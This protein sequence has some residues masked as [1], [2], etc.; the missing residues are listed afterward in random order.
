[1][2]H[3]GISSM[4][5]T[6]SAALL[7][8]LWFP[9][10]N[11]EVVLPGQSNVPIAEHSFDFDVVEQKPRDFNFGGVFAH[12]V[13]S[14][15]SVNGFLAFETQVSIVSAPS[16]FLLDQV[17]RTDYAGFTT[18]AQPEPDRGGPLFPET[19]NRSGLPGS[20]VTF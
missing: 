15:I 20:T 14:V 7:V 17:A 4:V 18:N 11:A 6:W 2:A 9:L 13:D 10:A 3:M 16:G 1:M 5:R 19:A 8:A 12:V